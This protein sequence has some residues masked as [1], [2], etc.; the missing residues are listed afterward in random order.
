MMIVITRSQ[1]CLRKSAQTSRSVSK[2]FLQFCRKK[3][4]KNFGQASRAHVSFG[5][6]I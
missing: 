2:T 5:P 1:K 3:H 6:K 4:W